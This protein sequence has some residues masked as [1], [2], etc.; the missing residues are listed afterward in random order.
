MTWHGTAGEIASR[1]L[2]HWITQT[3]VHILSV[4]DVE[5]ELLLH[6]QKSAV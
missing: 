4:D 3:A 2:N 1:S 6:P 5:A